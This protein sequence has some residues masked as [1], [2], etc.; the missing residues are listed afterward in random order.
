MIYFHTL[1]LRRSSSIF[2]AFPVSYFVAQDDRPIAFMFCE[3]WQFATKTWSTPT[4][5]IATYCWTGVE[6]EP[7][8]MLKRNCCMLQMLFVV[9]CLLSSWMER[10]RILPL[11]DKG[12]SW[13]Q[14]QLQQ[15]G[16]RPKIWALLLMMFFAFF[17]DVAE[18]V[19][20]VVVF[21]FF[22]C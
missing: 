18:Y 8:K 4:Q 21:F 9:G 5:K 17:I 7:A 16:G 1:Q 20:A 19:F 12:R 2:M 10:A 15:C 22:G 14:L 6:Q 3:P 11:Y 13:W